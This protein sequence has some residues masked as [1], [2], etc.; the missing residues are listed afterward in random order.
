[1]E[2]TWEERA[3]AAMHEGERAFLDIVLAFER[4]AD[5]TSTRDMAI[6]N[7]LGELHARIPKSKRMTLGEKAV[8]ERVLARHRAAMAQKFPELTPGRGSRM[9]N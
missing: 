3:T 4:Q 6:L 8:F 2:M 9:L 5:P 1:M 7:D